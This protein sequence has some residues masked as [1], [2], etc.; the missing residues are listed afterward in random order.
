MEMLRAKVRG[1][2]VDQSDVLAAIH[3]ATRPK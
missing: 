2:L 1:E 3:E